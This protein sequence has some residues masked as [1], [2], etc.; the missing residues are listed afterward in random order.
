MTTL[1]KTIQE[2]TTSL[3]GLV[4]D[5]QV[6]INKDYA[7]GLFA[8]PVF[9]Q[10]KNSKT[11]P[12]ELAKK[13]SEALNKK[14]HVFFEKTTPLSGYINFHVSQHYYQEAVTELFEEK[15][16]KKN[17]KTAV[18]EFSQPN[19]GKP[20]HVGHIRSTIL[21][22]VVSNLLEE[23]GWKVVR[24]NYYGDSGSQVAKLILAMQEL[25][26]LPK[27]KNEKDLL[28]YYIEIHKKI[29]E[30]PSLAE[31]SRS[32]LEKIESGDS[33]VLKELKLVRE[34]SYE[35]FNRNYAL[36][37]IKFDEELGES[38]FIEKSKTIVKECLDKKIAKIE[39]GGETLAVLEPE[40]PNLVIL[41]SNGTTLYSTRDLALAEYKYKKYAFD[42][43]LILTSSEQNLYFKQVILLL[44]KLKKPFAEKYN[45][46]GFGLITLEEGKMSSRE[47]RVVFLEDVLNQAVDLARQQIKEAYTE[48]ELMKISHH[49]GIGSV[50]FAILRI[51]A[52]KNIAFSLKKIVS[53]EGD[54]GAYIQYT[55][56]RAKNILRKTK[57]EA[58]IHELNNSESIKLA[59]TLSQFH[60]IIEQCAENKQTQPLCDYLLKLSADY[61]EF[62]SKQP[63]LK[64][65]SKQLMQTNLALTKA[66]IQVIEKGLKLLG[67]NIP[68]RM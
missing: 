2:I 24:M 36:L 54:T 9:Q 58:V 5:P 31:K 4:E 59:C 33:K 62:Y 34:K 17:N 14:K 13:V 61:S 68:E 1:K 15:K 64:A 18:I 60:S 20:F 39:P 57:E 50:K 37:G 10:A 23:I 45:H 48:K 53:F 47:G 28:A 26:D 46:S 40:L 43:S 55:C 21:G 29:E 32:I 41:R 35:A 52:E 8:V 16:H 3:K 51:N 49:V 65:E 19:V 30:D 63:V 25:K 56:V 67:I 42:Y 38:D 44:N 66:T 11:N 7:L 12:M 27:I 6:I 22:D